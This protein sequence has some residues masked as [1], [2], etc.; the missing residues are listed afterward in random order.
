[1]S[2][3]AQDA[4]AGPGVLSLRVRNPDDSR[5]PIDPTRRGGL[6][7]RVMAAT[8]WA[9]SLLAHLGL[10]GAGITAATGAGIPR[11]APSVAVEFGEQR[12]V[13]ARSATVAAQAPASETAAPARPIVATPVFEAQALIEA[14][15]AP[16]AS[17][18]VASWDAPAPEPSD[19]LRP[20]NDAPP[21]LFGARGERAATRVVY[22]IDGSGAMVA[23]L[24]TIV[25][26]LEQS[27]SRLGAGCWFQALLFREGGYATA[28]GVSPASLLAAT[29]AN[30]RGVI[31]WLHEV[32]AEKRSD[33]LPAL[34]RA[35]DYRPDLVFL[36]SKGLGD[37]TMSERAAQGRR[38]AVLARLESLNPASGPSGRRPATIKTIQFFD[39]DGA[40][41]LRE[42]GA[43]HGG[44]DG[45]KFKSRKDLGLE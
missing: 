7:G 40:G 21:E 15:A 17:L 16:E 35:L 12:P 23:A 14:P 2:V 28:P 39:T 5:M 4:G 26:E 8:P 32:R 27:I 20:L 18:G 13:N 38:D 19:A 34:E 41:L 29:D 43:R 3:A 25:R 11:R 36:V 31:R 37:P 10:V 22:V 9:V 33:P 1:M 44:P 24:P 45:Y 42:I 30:K 6:P